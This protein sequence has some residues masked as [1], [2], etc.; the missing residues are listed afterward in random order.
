[1]RFMI[2]PVTT[3]TSMTIV[4]VMIE[5]LG[6]CIPTSSN[7]P[8]LG[9]D[10]ISRWGDCGMDNG[11]WLRHRCQSPRNYSNRFADILTQ[12]VYCSCPLL[13]WSGSITMIFLY[14][15][16]Q[17]S[18]YLTNPCDNDP[19][20][21]GRSSVII[22]NEYVTARRCPSVCHCDSDCK[23]QATSTLGDG[24]LTATG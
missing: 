4:T 8:R 5:C 24:I 10:A 7:P 9:L 14:R 18:V 20:I 23:M 3:C 16:I 21:G 17:K 11:A 22:T 2:T 13:L 1:M 12:S 19:V 15:V 6:R